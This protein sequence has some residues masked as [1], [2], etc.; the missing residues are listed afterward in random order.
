[1]PRSIHLQ[2]S[3]ANRSNHRSSP[4][5]TL[6]GSDNLPAS[7]R[8]ACS[9]HQAE[10]PDGFQQRFLWRANDN[11]RNP[12]FD[13]LANIY[14]ASICQ[15]ATCN[16]KL[17]REC[18]GTSLAYKLPVVRRKRDA[19]RWPETLNRQQRARRLTTRDPVQ[20]TALQERSQGRQAGFKS[21]A[22]SGLTGGT[23]QPDLDRPGARQPS[24]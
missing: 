12:T 7:E 22:N 3:S 15:S 23:G 19:S 2:R 14:H 4:C 6:R 13:G 20:E 24:P 18:F 5:E 1:M 11:R 17:P 9:H 10:T 16:D 8:H 21:T